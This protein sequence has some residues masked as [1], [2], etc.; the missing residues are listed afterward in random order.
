MKQ[1]SFK[2]KICTL[3]ISRNI[4]VKNIVNIAFMYYLAL[5]EKCLEVIQHT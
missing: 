4:Y 1:R 5:E 2:C 3:R